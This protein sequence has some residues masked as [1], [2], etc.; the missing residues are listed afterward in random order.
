[1]VV[2]MV[3]RLDRMK[4]QDDLLDVIPALAQ[5]IPAVQVVLV[6]DGRDG[7]RLR[8]RVHHSGLRNH[9]MFT[10]LVPEAEV[11]GYLLAM[12]VVAL[13]SYQEG[14][15]RALVEAL[16]CGRPVVGYDTGGIPEVCIDGETGRLVRA[17]D[18]RG[19]GGVLAE[20]LS[21]AALRERLSEQG[22]NH[23][24]THFTAD[25]MISQVQGL[26]DRLLADG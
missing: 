14:Q 20:L 16:M 19:L 25:R 13:P 10:G 24:L 4:G 1:P 22:Q 8:R 11:P 17:G 2:G 21:D 12:D 23:A 7:D 3:A 9:V 15:G 6:G 18:R 26:Y 5:Q